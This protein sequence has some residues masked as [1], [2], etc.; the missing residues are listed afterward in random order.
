MRQIEGQRR[1]GV[2]APLSLDAR[3]LAAKRVA[4]IGADDA[5]CIERAS[6][7]KLDR[8]AITLWFDGR[9]RGGNTPK[10][11]GFCRALLERRD[12]M[13]V[14]DIVAEALKSD[15]G[16][17]EY[18]LRRAQQAGRVVDDADGLERRGLRAAQ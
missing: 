1:L 15:L 13:P 8:N 3:R 2:L 6:V 11:G 17:L 18:H 9:H 16:G 14:L 10:A 7:S 5:P 4:S 12:E